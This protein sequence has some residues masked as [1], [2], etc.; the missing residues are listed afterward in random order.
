MEYVMV[1]VPEELLEDVQRHLLELQWRLQRTGT[2]R[3]DPE[4]L[5]AIWDEVD[6]DVR[7]LLVVAAESN[8]TRRPL[9]LADAAERIG[10]S[11]RSVAGMVME[12]A[13]LPARY[14]GSS[15]ILFLL[16]ATDESAQGQPF[17]RRMFLAIAD[18]VA[19]EVKRLPG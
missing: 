2:D 15:F 7:S 1:P 19:R 18:D 12:L 14:E 6:A 3:W 5:R 10:V 8:R 4:V 13:H 16:P 9:T 17:E 11:H